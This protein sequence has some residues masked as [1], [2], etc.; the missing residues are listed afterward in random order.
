MN[1]THVI[2]GK[3]SIHAALHNVITRLYIVSG[4]IEENLKKNFLRNRDRVFSLGGSYVLRKTSLAT[5][6]EFFSMLGDFDMAA[7]DILNVDN[8]FS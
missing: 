7:T 2:L 6:S 4:S 8:I 3:G 1:M 5:N